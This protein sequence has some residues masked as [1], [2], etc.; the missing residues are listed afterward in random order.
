MKFLNLLESFFKRTFLCFS[1]IV[2][3]FTFTGSIL[4]VEDSGKVLAVSQLMGFFSFS[5]L[6]SLS[7]ELSFIF[8]KNSV[9]KGAVK[10]ILSLVSFVLVFFTNTSFSLYLEEKQNPA[11]SVIVITFV[12]VLIYAAC[13][14]FGLAYK[15]LKNKL[16][17]SL[18]AYD[19][20]YIDKQ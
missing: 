1:M 12:Y 2:L 18:K 15:S 3:V 13:S 9:V 7:A 4:N 17:N 8:K 6:F 14:L 19:N 20:V 16:E 10:F 5:F 11:F